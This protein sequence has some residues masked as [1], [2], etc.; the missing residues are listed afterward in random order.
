MMKTVWGDDVK[1]STVHLWYNRSNKKNN[2][3]KKKNNPNYG[4]DMETWEYRT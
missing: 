4:T 2:Y 3:L 1:R